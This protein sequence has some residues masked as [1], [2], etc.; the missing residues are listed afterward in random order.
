MPMM[1]KNDLKVD[2]LHVHTLMGLHKSLLDAA[3][4]L[5][6]KIVFTAHD[7]QWVCPNHMLMIP[8]NKQLCFAC[9]GGKYG[10]CTKNNCIHNCK[11][12]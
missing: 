6:I 7:Y 8:A 9:E 1:L 2:V 3:K 4:D 5:S 10:N 12:K 11:V